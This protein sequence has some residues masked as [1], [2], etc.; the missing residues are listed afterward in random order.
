[1]D[2]QEALNILGLK[3]GASN[4]DVKKAF[5][6]KAVEFHPDRNKDIDAEAKFKKANEASQLLEQQG[7]VPQ[8]FVGNPFNIP[9]Y[10]NYKTVDFSDFPGMNQKMHD[11]FREQFSVPFN[12]RFHVPIE[13]NITI[14]FDLSVL[15]GKHDIKYERS[16]ICK[17]CNGTKK[18]T[19]ICSKCY[20]K[21]F[22]QTDTSGKVTCLNC[23]GLGYV[24][25]IENC[26]ECNGAG[27][28]RV[29]EHINFNIPPGSSTGSRLILN[30]FGNY[31]SN[32]TYD[33]LIVVIAVLK[34]PDMNLSGVDVISKIEIS[35]LE[36][37]KGTKRTIRTIKGERTLTIPP[38][39]K[40][41]DNIKVNGFGIP[42]RG[43]HVFLIN[44]NYPEDV[45]QLIEVL[46]NNNISS[47]KNQE[48]KE[49]NG[50]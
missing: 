46:E 12:T 5:K 35:L 25:T 8:K 17:T 49:T 19:V 36:S 27:V 21:Q 18:K 29:T 24:P 34:D 47:D 40:N 42:D 6:Q 48:E 44:V 30:N 20:G 2:I 33:K 14:P 4:E 32:G 23:K 45:S 28:T 37:L 43:S 31:N 50:L 7:T 3:S 22:I 38:K 15:G 16:K 13:V 26:V 39:I 41:G 10:Q 1:M 9:F 11:S